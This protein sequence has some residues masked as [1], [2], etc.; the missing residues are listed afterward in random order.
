[1]G[2]ET[3]ITMSIDAPAITAFYLLHVNRVS[4]IALCDKSGKIVANLSA[5]DI[6]VTEIS[7]YSNAQGFEPS[8]FSAMMESCQIY[9]TKRY[10]SV[11]LRYL[12]F[13]TY[14]FFSL[15]LH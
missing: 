3:A 8:N 15:P 1:M 6:R 13:V 7:F 11:L 5:S 14:K 12:K 9:L 10:G 2:T 4:A